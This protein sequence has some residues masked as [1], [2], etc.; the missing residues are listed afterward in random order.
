MSIGFQFTGRIDRPEA[1]IEAAQALAEERNCRLA[2][3]EG[4]MKVAL[5]PLG[6]ELDILWRPGEDPEGPWLVRGGCVS[7]P[8][9]A[10]LHRAAVELLD[11]LP[12]YAL[13]V[14]DETG[15]FRHRDFQ[16]MKAEHFYPWLNTLVDVCRRESGKGVSG[17]QLCWDLNQYAPEDIPDTVVTPMGRFRLSELVDLVEKGGIEA[18]AGRFFLWNGRTQ[19]AKFF[20]NRAINALWE[21]CCFAPSSRSQEDAAIN[22]AILDDLERAAKLDP[23]LPLPRAAYEEV[24]A[25][26]DR[27]PALPEGRALEEEFSPGYRKGSVTHAVGALRLTLPGSYLYSWEQWE[28]GGAHRW[29]DGAGP[30]WRVSSYRMREGS[31]QFTGRLELLNGS[32]SRTLKGGALCWGWREIRENG[33]RLYQAECEVITGPFLYFLTA[34]CTGPGDLAQVAG[35]IGQLS[36]VSGAARRETVQAQGADDPPGPCI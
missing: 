14:E 24:C 20:R 36:V 27:A 10:G 18:L 16:R 35:V 34:T 12:I 13:T 31:A 3:G 32:E 9:G 8:A 4:G 2:V 22:A 21:Q 23:F 5:C 28:S 29:S 6:G 26:A 25:L 1:L 17:M 11:N 7:T 19:D 15:F 30:V 33:E